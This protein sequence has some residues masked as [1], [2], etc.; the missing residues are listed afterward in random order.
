M[1]ENKQYGTV[2]VTSQFRQVIDRLPPDSRNQL[3][4]MVA[5]RKEQLLAMY[6]DNG[7]LKFMKLFYE[8]FDTGMAERTKTGTSCKK[9]CHF[10]C[11]Q[12]VDVSKAEATAIGNYCQKHHIDIPAKDLKEQ[13][14]YSK[15]KVPLNPVPWCVFLKDGECSIYLVRPLACRK[16]Y[17]SSAPELC[18][19]VKYSPEEFKVDVIVFTL[20]ELEA[21][22]FYG[23]M[24]E[25][26]KTG[27]LPEMLL[28]YSK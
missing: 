1:T 2:A 23:V 27:R 5:N 26:E 18:D 20:P 15:A 25:K 16:Y 12:N 21:C 11:R 3:L 10:C 28:P 22:A 17:V 9:G 14:Q 6:Q 7:P 8:L 24:L 19:M 4:E 13:L